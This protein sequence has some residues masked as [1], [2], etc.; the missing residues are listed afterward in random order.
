MTFSAKVIKGSG[1]GK[2]IGTPTY[3]LDL[4]SI[5]QDFE[6]GIYALWA[7]INDI[8][9]P[10]VM[11]YGPRPVF[12]DTIS[13]E[14]HLLDEAPETATSVFVE[15]VK[16]LRDVRDFPTPD[17]LRMQMALDIHQAGELLRNAAR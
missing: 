12:Q 6:E 4:Q 9:H 8:A 10:A 16:R 2:G 5:P 13:C 7:T 1:R 17:D 11:H 15:T 3:N 14:V